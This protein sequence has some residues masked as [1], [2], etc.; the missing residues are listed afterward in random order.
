MNTLNPIQ[1]GSISSFTERRT[2]I[3]PS[4]ASPAKFSDVLTRELE[5]IEPVRFSG[6]ASARLTE[7]KIRWTASEDTQL[8]Q[9]VERLAK[10]GARESVVVMKDTV[11][12]VNVPN[13]TVIT[14]ASTTETNDAL[15][16]NI[17]SAAVIPSATTT[18]TRPDPM[19]EACAPR[20]DRCGASQLQE[21]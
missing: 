1:T 18:A 19:R 12:V 20:I 5:R 6:H 9:A 16:T 3:M 2:G 13:R 8:A 4:Q 10:K 11:L 21:V 17:D 15:F 14:I 7:R